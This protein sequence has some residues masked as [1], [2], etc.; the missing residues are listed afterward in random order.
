MEGK[1]QGAPRSRGLKSSSFGLLR[2][3]PLLTPEGRES[4]EGSWGSG[5]AQKTLLLPFQG[6]KALLKDRELQSPMFQSHFP[7]TRFKELVS[8]LLLS[9]PWAVVGF[10]RKF[11][12]R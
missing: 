7:V 8:F 5:D 11:R 12:G 1:R 9:L 6:L 3:H 10:S 4:P 2:A